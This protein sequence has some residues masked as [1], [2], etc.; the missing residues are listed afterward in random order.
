MKELKI[1]EK[2]TITLEYRPQPLCPDRPCR[3]LQVRLKDASVGRLWD[4]R[5]GDFNG[6]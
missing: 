6:V 3:I 1:G 2:V 4:N 5:G